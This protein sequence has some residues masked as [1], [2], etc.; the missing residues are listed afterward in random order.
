LYII[1]SI[2]NLAFS[3]ATNRYTSGGWLPAAI[4]DV[5]EDFTAGEISFLKLLTMA[6]QRM[7]ERQYQQEDGKM[8]LKAAG[9]FHHQLKENVMFKVVKNPTD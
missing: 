5:L 2:G 6:N 1:I 4:K 3:T 7:S 9:T 8:P